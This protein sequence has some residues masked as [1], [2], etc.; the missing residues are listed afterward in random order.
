M[1]PFIDDTDGKTAEASLTIAYTS[2]FLSKHGGAAAAKNDTTNLT[3]TGDARGYYDCVLNT[4]D[5]NTVGNL[6]IMAHITGALPVWQEFT[7]LPANAYDSL[8]GGTD[9][10]NADLTQIG[11]VAQSATD[12]KD[13]ADAGYNPATNKVQ[14]VVL[15]DTCTT[16]TDMAGTDNAA[17]ASVC[18]EARLSELDAATGGK[19][20]NQ[21]D[22]I[23]TDTTTDIPA[24]ISA[25]ND[26]AVT[27]ITGAEV[28]NDG[29]AISL[30]G[31]LKLV[32]SVLTGKSS[33]GGTTTIVFRDINDSKNRI[34]ATVDSS[35]NRTAVGTRD[36]T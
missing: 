15:V 8:V 17:L 19:M 10:L 25:L 31:A 2:V 3:G 34:S 22:V 24:S 33:G 20:A 14:G 26:I 4:T 21:V 18:T 29:T 9:T 36:A 23:Q 5:T 32:L 27:D 1:G 30:A 16:N 28:D 12:L 6:K 11:G 35:G 13:F 7:V